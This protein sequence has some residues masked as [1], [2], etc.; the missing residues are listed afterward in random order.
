VRKEDGVGAERVVDVEVRQ[1]RRRQHK[2]HQLN[3]GLG[4][5]RRVP[6]LGPL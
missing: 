6:L 1:G 4:W 3:L 2:K 5:V